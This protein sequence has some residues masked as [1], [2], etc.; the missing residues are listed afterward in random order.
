MYCENRLT[1]TI[2]SAVVKTHCKPETC[3]LAENA[4]NMLGNAFTLSILPIKG[5][6]KRKNVMLQ[7]WSAWVL[8]HVLILV[9]WGLIKCYITF[10][11][12]LWTVHVNRLLPVGKDQGSRARLGSFYISDTIAEQPAA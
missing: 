7:E 3:I 4:S 10:F 8:V 2:F 5:V 1:K 9:Q 12:F 11:F 6:I